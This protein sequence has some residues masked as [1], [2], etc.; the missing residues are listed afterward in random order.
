MLLRFLLVWVLVDLCGKEKSFLV[1]TE[2][3]KRVE[4]NRRHPPN[5]QWLSLAAVDLLFCWRTC[6]TFLFRFLGAGCLS[7]LN[8]P[9]SHGGHL[10]LKLLVGR[11]LLFW[12]YKMLDGFLKSLEWLFIPQPQGNTWHLLTSGVHQ[13]L[14]CRGLPLVS[15][16]ISPDSAELLSVWA[17]SCV[18]WPQVSSPDNCLLKHEGDLSF[19]F[20]IDLLSSLYSLGTFFF[21]AL[22]AAVSSGLSMPLCAGF[23]Y[24]DDLNCNKV[25]FLTC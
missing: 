8:H 23:C 25:K 3:C 21:K 7:L 13:W 2:F 1:V 19:S 14:R 11:H 5:L 17:L 9:H 12:V 24:I 15:L 4:A 20:I 22:G 6:R 10:G 18:C 16:G